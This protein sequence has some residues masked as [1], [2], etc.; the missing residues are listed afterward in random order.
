MQVPIPDTAAPLLTL[1]APK[2]KTNTGILAQMSQKLKQASEP[3]MHGHVFLNNQHPQQEI[4]RLI[5]KL[6][7]FLS[8]C[9]SLQLAFVLNRHLI[10]YY[11]TKLF[12]AF[13]V[14][15][16]CNFAEDTRVLCSSPLHR[17]ES[18]HEAFTTTCSTSYVESV[19]ESRL[20]PTHVISQSNL[21]TLECIQSASLSPFFSH[22]TLLKSH[23]DYTLLFQCD[24]DHLSTGFLHG[25][26][27]DIFHGRSLILVLVFFPKDKVFWVE[28]F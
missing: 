5:H 1:G 8:S 19:T 11:N 14:F 6:S 24:R 7:F 23:L 25:L 15:F 3:H 9:F 27:Q 2:Q 10:R 26:T 20:E 21:P 22:S 13:T 17:K 28:Q 16:P 18:E 4:I 12:Q